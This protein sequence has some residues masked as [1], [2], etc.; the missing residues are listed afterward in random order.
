MQTQTDVLVLGGGAAGLSLALRL[1]DTHHVSLIAKGALQEGSTLYAQGGIAAVLDDQDNLESHIRDT[2]DAGAGLC[3]PAAVEFTVRRA[4][5]NIEW[6]IDQGVAFTHE[7]PSD[8]ATPYHLTREGGHSH[9][10]I[11]HAADATGRAVETTLEGRARQ[12]P[13]S[14]CWRTTSPST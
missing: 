5:R 2:L 6:L 11:I 14:R 8:A 12:A 7:D 9:R 3:D 4:R 13:T 1:A 10:R